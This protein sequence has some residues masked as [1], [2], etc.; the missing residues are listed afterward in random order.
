MAT[1][2]FEGEPS[3]ISQRGQDVSPRDMRGLRMVRTIGRVLCGLLGC[4]GPVRPATTA[5]YASLHSDGLICWLL[6]KLV[7]PWIPTPQSRHR[8]GARVQGNS[9]RAQN[10][11]LCWNLVSFPVAH[12]KIRRIERSKPNS[13]IRSDAQGPERSSR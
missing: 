13:R 5:A 3:G 9:K 11:R 8:T 10:G 6:L 4:C 1:W 12:G 2:E 7:R